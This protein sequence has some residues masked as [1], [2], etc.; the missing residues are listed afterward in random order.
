MIK[1]AMRTGTWAVL[2][3]CHLAVSWLPTLEKVC[4]EMTAEGTHADYRLWLT[5][6]PSD[7]FPVSLLQNGIKMTNEPPAGI[8]A[9]LLRSYTSDPISDATF[10]KT[11]KK[12]A[13][14]AF[15][16]LLYGLCFFHAI[17]QERKNF[18]PLGWNIPYE[19]NESD[20]RISVRQLQ[21]FL[22][23]Y[24]VP[25]L[26]ALTYLTG[27]CNYGGRVTDDRD[28]RCLLSLL[29]TF[30]TIDIMDDGYK[31]SPSG[32]YV[33]PPKSSYAG[34]VQYIQQLPQTQHPEVF[35]IHE[36][37][38]ITK[39]LKE[40]NTLLTAILNTQA[41]MAASGGQKGPE[42]LAKDIAADILDQL[43]PEF[44][45]AMAQKRFPV[46]YMESM[47]TVLIQELV[48]FS[49]LLRTIKDSLVSMNKAIKGLVVMSA[50][51]EEVVN[52]LLVGRVPEMWA[53]K[54]YP[55]LKPLVFIYF[56]VTTM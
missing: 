41:R 26:S 48:R 5:S 47:N 18:G 23:E 2:Q 6:Y 33:V 36:N 9:N 11:T 12:T 56:L 54:S 29:S 16:K 42:E 55:S 10:F 1:S 32:A 40:S 38:N 52:S 8:R 20:L 22:N 28:R 25:P 24:D 39:D 13:E 50:E 14:H 31:F 43:P 46:T 45:T 27:E 37:G 30:Y 15:E 44:D 4:A 19:F 51:I 53:S 34:Y 35:G 21:K 7:K 3:N 49:R 17:V